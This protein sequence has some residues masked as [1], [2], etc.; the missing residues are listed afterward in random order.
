[1]HDTSNAPCKCTDLFSL[2]MSPYCTQF[3]QLDSSGDGTLD[4]GEFKEAMKL[5]GIKVPVSKMRSLFAMFDED[6]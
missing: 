1:M 2:L 3:N 4:W 5:L 6:E